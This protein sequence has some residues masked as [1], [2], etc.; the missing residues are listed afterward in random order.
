[1]A[2]TDGKYTTRPSYND[3]PKPIR[4]GL[5][6]GS[7]RLVTHLQVSPY[8]RNPCATFSASNRLFGTFPQP[9]ASAS[10]ARSCQPSPTFRLSDPH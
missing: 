8:T 4:H 1:M 2:G 10:Q 9:S 7:N 6:K 5:E 3:A